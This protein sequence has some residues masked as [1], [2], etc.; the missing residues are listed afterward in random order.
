MGPIVDECKR[1]YAGKSIKFVTFDFTTADT[2]ARSKAAARAN[3][4]GNIYKSKGPGTGFVLLYDT[5]SKKVVA[6][7]SMR[8]SIEEWH[9]AIDQALGEG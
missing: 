9:A 6:T 7:L 4:V 5:E 2:K 3:G 8:N 1:D